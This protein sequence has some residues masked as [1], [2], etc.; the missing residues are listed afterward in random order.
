MFD[1]QRQTRECLGTAVARVLLELGVG[2]KVGSKVGT[3]GES[4][5]TLRAGERTLSG[6]RAQVPLEQPRP[7]E[8]LAAQLA[9]ARQR[10]RPDVHLER[11]ERRVQLAAVTARQ[12]SVSG[13]DA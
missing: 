6:V 5:A 2:L 11:A 10:V 13:D 12:L 1:E 3:I 7:R 4:A 9:A 8:R